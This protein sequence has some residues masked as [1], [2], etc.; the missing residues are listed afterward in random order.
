MQ[1]GTYV[2]THSNSTLGSGSGEG[3]ASVRF[4]AIPPADA[5]NEE[6]LGVHGTL[7]ARLP[8][9]GGGADATLSASF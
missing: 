5:T 9:L 4:S 1:A 7:T 2:L 8:S 6:L 3:S